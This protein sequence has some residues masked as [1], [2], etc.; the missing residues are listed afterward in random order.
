MTAAQLCRTLQQLAFLVEHTQ[1]TR[2]SNS[3]CAVGPKAV[4][5]KKR[6]A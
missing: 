1:T 5:E 6:K 2:S 3:D 4:M